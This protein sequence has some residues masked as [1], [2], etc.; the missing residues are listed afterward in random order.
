MK[1]ATAIII[2]TAFSYSFLWLTDRVRS[3]YVPTASFFDIYAN[4][5]L[6]SSEQS[7]YVYDYEKIKIFHYFLY[8][9]FSLTHW[10]WVTIIG[11]DNGLSHGQRQAIFLTKLS[12]IPQG[13]ISVKFY[14]KFK[15]FH[16]M[17]STWKCRLRNGGHF[18][19]ASMCWV[20]VMC[21]WWPSTDA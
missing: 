1:Q 10:D 13:N 3:V 2:Y 9:S 12:I 5:S 4:W 14:L 8:W 6:R 7:S 17:K 21:S 11:S 16:S 20:Y 19:S 15:S 18:V